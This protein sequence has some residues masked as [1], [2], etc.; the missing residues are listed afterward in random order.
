MGDILTNYGNWERY[1]DT[2]FYKDAY[3]VELNS[4][5]LGTPYE[6][7]LDNIAYYKGLAAFLRNTE[8][9]ER[10]RRLLLRAYMKPSFDHDSYDDPINKLFPAMPTDNLYIQRALK[11]LCIVYTEKPTREITGRQAET[12]A[13]ALDKMNYDYQML[14]IHRALKLMNE[15]AVTVVTNNK[16]PILKYLTP[17]NYRVTYDDYM[18]VKEL[19]I[20]FY[21]VENRKAIH[22]YRVWTADTYTVKDGYLNNVPFE[23]NGVNYT[24]M[25]NPFKEIP[26]EVIKMEDDNEPVHMSIGG[27]LYELLKAQLDCNKLQFL[28]NENLDYN[29]FTTWVLTN[30]GVTGKNFKMG[31]GK[32]LVV[33][34]VND[35]GDLPPNID[36]ITPT[37]QYLDIEELKSL[38][39]KK[40]LKSL[41]L[42]T[43]IIE[44]NPGVATS[45]VALKIDR[46]ELEELR[47]EDI[48][49]LRVIEDSLINKIARVLS[50]DPA[51]IYRG[52]FNG[53]YYTEIDYIEQSIFTE[54]DKELS[55]Q[56]EL[57]KRGLITP[58]MYVNRLI[59]NDTIT[60]DEDAIKYIQ[61]NLLLYKQTQ[62]TTNDRGTSGG[63]YED[64]TSSASEQVQAEAGQ[65]REGD[66]TSSE[67]D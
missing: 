10:D 20:P 33:D 56:T 15:V 12:L 30:F 46:M 14:K 53:E 41:G 64:N 6:N 35:S 7:E 66:V 5:W 63:L 55:Y 67:T 9:G 28:A 37:A 57:F 31:P 50:N 65:V 39:I 19:W 1:N 40:T 16:K 22:Y 60:T 24:I 18:N 47:K 4:L 43:S 61:E 8:F 42:P 52:K 26:Y 11:N 38:R 2:A 62:E 23:Y 25:P 13:A 21:K 51:S 17:D 3:L 59:S 36:T 54:P 48:T 29:G 58:S 27:G 49:R 34:G 32:A 45:G 44:D